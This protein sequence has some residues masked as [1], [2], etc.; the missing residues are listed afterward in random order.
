MIFVN[1]L[2]KRNFTIVVEDHYF[3]TCPKNYPIETIVYEKGFYQI[4]A[5]DMTSLQE[6][7]ADS[8]PLE[9]DLGKSS[10][11]QSPLMPISKYKS[12]ELKKMCLDQGISLKTD[13]GKAKVKKVLYDELILSLLTQ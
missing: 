11:Y 1:E 13:G 5:V 10:I 3:P 8:I 7:P 6:G 12:D 4:H 2:Y 9:N